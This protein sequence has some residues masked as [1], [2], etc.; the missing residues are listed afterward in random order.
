MRPDSEIRHDVEAELRWSPDID[1]TGISVAVSDSIV[2]LTG[3]VDSY[4]EKYQAEHAAK[5]VRGV[6]GVA[7]DVQVRATGATGTDDPSI[8]RGAVAA[9]RANLP[10]AADRIKVVVSDGLLTLEG[11]LEWNFERERVEDAVRR[12]RGVRMVNNQIRIE[13][14]VQPLE[15][16][17][18][19]EDAFR[20]SAE[21]D[22]DA[23]TV[24]ADGST[25]TLKGKVQTWKERLQAQ[26]TAWSAPGVASVRNEIEIVS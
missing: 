12:L 16:K 9:I 24:T 15:I 21:V 19:I 1:E 7:D 8:A 26:Q 20:R 6:T 14:R 10:I 5:R 25:V 23:I 18:R 3:F 17:R 11:Q 4:S 13:P 22:A 2:T